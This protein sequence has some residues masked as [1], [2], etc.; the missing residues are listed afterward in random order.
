MCMIL[1]STLFVCDQ[2]SD[3]WEH[4]ELA[5]ELESD[6]RDTVDWGRKWLVDFSAGKTQVVFFTSLIAL[7]QDSPYWIEI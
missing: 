5:F 4:L 3:L 1:F 2:T 6:I 7:I